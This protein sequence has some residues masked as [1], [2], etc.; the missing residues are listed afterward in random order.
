MVLLNREMTRYSMK[1]GCLYVD[2][3]WLGLHAVVRFHPWKPD[4]LT[5]QRLDLDRGVWV[6]DF[7]DPGL[8]L[9]QPPSQDARDQTHPVHRFCLH[10]PS[11]VRNRASAFRHLQTSLLQV[12]A[13]CDKAL[14]LFEHTPL[15]LWLILERSPGIVNNIDLLERLLRLRMPGILNVL[16]RKD[17]PHSGPGIPGPFQKS[18]VRFLRSIGI[19]EGNIEEL[20]LIKRA[21]QDD[22][23]VHRFRHC[24]DI[25]V[26][27][28]AVWQYFEG[29]DEVVD[30]LRESSLLEWLME[31]PYEF[32]YEAK[33]L[34][35]H[36]A[37]NWRDTLRMARQLEDDNV[38]HAMIRCRTK[39]ELQTMHDLLTD[40]INERDRRARREA[41][42]RPFPEPPIPGCDGI[43]PLR[44]FEELAEEGH[45]MH[46]CVVSYASAVREGRSYI[47]RIISP[48]RATLEIVGR[49]P[50]A[51]I[52]QLKL[53]RNAEPSEETWLQIRQ[54]LD[55][56][57]RSSRVRAGAAGSS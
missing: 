14:Q 54:W 8:I 11:P 51:R 33:A 37:C 7:L 9:L 48:Q 27:S 38:L 49:G 16:Y 35:H 21:V 6:S 18:H 32:G 19:R 42:L 24:N 39:E 30:V 2:F 46:H 3:R 52:G 47:Y 13:R 34:T 40:R 43:I 26:L 15:L 20:G 29:V 17:R 44:S 41:N 5:V 31:R 57:R 1:S 36:V 50:N 45:L 56:F 10:I 12:L 55:G 4:G 22:V 53:A 25:P 28:L 23:C